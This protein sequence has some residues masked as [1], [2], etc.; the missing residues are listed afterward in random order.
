MLYICLS[1]KIANQLRYFIELSYKGTNYHGWQLQ[2]NAI[3]IQEV[4]TKAFTTIF[5]IPVELVGA[6]RTD[7]GVH[8]AQL[9][10]HFDIDSELN[11][12]DIIYK[13]N[14]LLPND[15]VVLNLIKTSDNAH[16]RFDAVSRTYEYRIFLGRDPFL[17]ETSF[18]IIN[19]L[20]PVDKLNVA[21]S[22][23]LSYTNFKC[24]SRSNTDVKTYNCNILRAEWILTNKQ[25]V[26]HI[27]A[28]R[29]LRNMVRAIVG[30]MLEVGSGKTSIE[31]FKK[32]IESQDRRN[33]G[34]SAPPQG[35][36]L[37]G[38]SYPKTIFAHE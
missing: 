36:F 11:V 1:T 10:A 5:R 33:A 32:I 2:P 9:F 30:T 34:P 8:A 14:A 35:L 13:V 17:T 24:F 4:L 22:I 3:T 21:A 16:A 31:D 37:T 12:T 38:V 28:N 6:G 23:L 18:Q 29:F 26:F 7:T 15:I 27:S 19:K 25:L 20:I